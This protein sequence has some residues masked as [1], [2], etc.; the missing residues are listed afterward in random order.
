MEEEVGEDLDCFFDQWVYEQGHPHYEIGWRVNPPTYS[1]LPVYEVEFAISQTQNQSVHY[2][3]FRM[4]LEIGL[5][6]DDAEEI[7]T[8]T[9]SISYQRLTLEVEY[10]PDSFLLD[11]HNR[12]LCEI[13]Y[14]DDIDDV[15]EP[16]IEEE[17]IVAAS[18][19]L[20]TDEVF[21]N[22]LC[23]DF[24][25]PSRTRVT[26]SVF[27]ASGRL[28]TTFYQGRSEK[29]HRIYPLPQLSAGCYFIRLE[30]AEGEVKTVK[31]VKMR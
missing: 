5:Y 14:H 2:F 22:N 27:D 31:T 8:F 1:I 29:L 7:F 10:E 25:N 9:D 12:V 28:V 23:V 6:H 18:L 24:T 3:P 16:G 15:P 11:P 20:K 13:T 26:L 4:P 17:P 21:S 19:N 30:S